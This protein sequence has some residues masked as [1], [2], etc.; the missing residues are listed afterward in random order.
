MDRPVGKGA[1]EE[2]LL[3]KVGTNPKRNVNLERYPS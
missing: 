2:P 1:V 3:E